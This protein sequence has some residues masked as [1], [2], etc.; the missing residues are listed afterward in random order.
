MAAQDIEHA[1]RVHDYIATLEE[2][3]DSSLKTSPIVLGVPSQPIILKMSDSPK[4]YSEYVEPL[5]EDIGDHDLLFKAMR[6][7]WPCINS[8]SKKIPK[9]QE[10]Y[11]QQWNHAHAFGIAKERGYS[12]ADELLKEQQVAYGE[13]EAYY[14][15][16]E[17]LH[18][19]NSG[20]W[21]RKPNF[22]SF[23]KSYIRW[24]KSVKLITSQFI[25]P[26][27]GYE[28]TVPYILDQLWLIAHNDDCVR[29]LGLEIDGEHHIFNRGQS[30][31]LGRDKYLKELGYELYRVASW[32][33]RVDP[34]RVVCEFLKASGIFPDALNYLIGSE[35]TSINE[36]KC[37]L[38][39]APMVRSNWDW[40]QE[41]QIGRST[42]L[43]H[44]SCITHQEKRTRYHH[45]VS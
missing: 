29:L 13:C 11:C 27:S 43:A 18:G 25:I 14:A 5:Y 19:K 4:S 22:D 17:T 35:L 30:K 6:T 21:L 1:V 26:S 41:C 37:G 44:K 20:I 39:H 9:Q 15:V 3:T 38:C 12:V 33:C 36:Y 10:K 31:T 24:H 8:Y 34:Y 45:F 40:I 16:R 42:V 2:L 28:N 32:W 7:G 23:V